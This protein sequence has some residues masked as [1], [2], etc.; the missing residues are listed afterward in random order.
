MVKTCINYSETNKD[1]YKEYFDKYSFPLSSFQKFAIEAIVDGHHS[2]SCVPTG[3]GKTLPALFAIDFF[4]SKGKKVIYTSPIKA[5]SNQKYY[6]FT[7]KFPNISIGLLTGDIKINPEADVLIMTAEILQN[8]LYRKKQKSSQPQELKSSSL[9]MFDMDFDNELACVIQDEIHMINDA[10]RGHVWEGI[11][12]LLPKHVQMVM[13]SATLDKPE[14]FAHWIENRGN[15]LIDEDEENNFNNSNNDKK[16]V[17]LATSNFRHVPLTHYSFI[18]CNTGIFKAIEKDKELEKEILGSIDKLVVLQSPIG[19]FNDVNYHKMKKMLTLF[20]QKKVYVKRS[21]VL[22]QLCKYMVEHN[23]LP[24]VCFILSKKQIEISAYEITIPLLEDDSKVTYIVRRECEQILRSKIPNYQEYLELPE[25]LK[26]I[27]LLEK[28]IAIHHSGVM[29]ILREMVEILFEKGYI[30]FLFA[31][32]TCS[33]G[34]NMPI[35]TAIFTDVKKFD[36]NCMRMLHPHEYNQASGRAGRRGI[37][38]VGH[39][40]HLSNLFRNIELSEYKIMMQGKPQILVSKFKISYN[41]LLNLIMFGDK[42][43]LKFCKCSMIQDHIDSNLKIISNQIKKLESDIINIIPTRT[44]KQTVDR[45][46]E[47]YELR[48]VSV[49]RK[50]KDIDREIQNIQDEN[51]F[52]ETDK[53][54]IIKHNEKLNEL[55]ELKKQ[56]HIDDSYLDNNIKKILQI[57]RESK[58]IK[59]ENNNNVLTDIGFIASQLREVHCLVFA[60]ILN[61]KLFELLDSKQIIIVLSC[62]TNIN[63]NEEQRSIVSS[64]N[65]TNINLIINEIIMLYNDYQDFENETNTFTGTDFTFHYDLI[66]YILLWVNCN[67]TA[68]CKFV[69][70]SLEKDKGIFLGE[71]VKAITK[72]N[73]ISS[74]IEKI[75]ESIGNI[76]LLSKLHEIPQLTLKYVATSQSLYV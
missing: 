56:F 33:V 30:K 49:N 26:V 57:M 29:P 46:L 75:A 34:L 2:L 5:L 37:D 15:M 8:T 42:D 3:S 76:S 27:S 23:M 64:S 61:N 24:A 39:V 62:F 58:F 73:N 48:K 31:T 68:E 1:Q 40:I 66:E 17:Y 12:L 63:V 22:N 35:K 60:N 28:G 32:E 11:I 50:K 25:Y 21:H 74:E 7:Q 16:E 54:I 59:T 6:E 55:V 10:D 4:V 44:S 14:K 9:L 47:L 13:L 45:Y 36:G 38:T 20:E 69:L 43:Y 19:E 18:T 53:I 51:K 65:D 70:Q 67:S 72:I 52:I 41:L 71:F